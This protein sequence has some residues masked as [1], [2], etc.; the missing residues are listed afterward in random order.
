[1]LKDGEGGEMKNFIHKLR[2]AAIPLAVNMYM[3]VDYEYVG[4]NKAQQFHFVVF[5]LFISYPC[6]F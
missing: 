4:G 5:A 6:V 2:E 1:M 3:L